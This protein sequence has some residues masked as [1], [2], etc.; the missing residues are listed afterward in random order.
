MIKLTNIL[1]E[2]GDASSQP[3]SFAFYGDYGNATVTTKDR[4]R[5]EVKL[6]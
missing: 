5:V 2:I 4:G 6:K 3:Y 1:K